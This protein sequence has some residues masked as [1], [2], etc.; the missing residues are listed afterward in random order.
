MSFRDTSCLLK[1]SAGQK[2]RRSCLS[3]PAPSRHFYSLVD[4]I[5]PPPPRA[6]ARSH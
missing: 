4:K 1:V 2:V 3:S 5:K 6:E